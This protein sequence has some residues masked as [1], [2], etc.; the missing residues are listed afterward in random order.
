METYTVAKIL[1]SKEVAGQRGIQHNVR[2]TTNENGD[3]SI[4]GF[5]D[6]PIKEGQQITGEIVQK[7]GTDR[8]GNE[9]VYN[10][11]KAPSKRPSAPNSVGMS[12]DQY[13]LIMRELHAINTNVLRIWQEVDPEKG[14]TSA[15]TPVPDFTPATMNVEPPVEA[16]SDDDFTPENVEF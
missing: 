12:Q 5:F 11:F 7:P 13:T 9:V 4:S 8:N 15:G 1:F 6:A 3:M 16:Y 14:M 10:N 2:F